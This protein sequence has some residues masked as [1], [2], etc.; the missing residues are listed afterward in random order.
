MW[1]KMMIARKRESQCYHLQGYKAVISSVGEK[2]LRSALGG[3]TDLDSLSRAE[4]HIALQFPPLCS[5]L[6]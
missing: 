4:R 3:S 2:Y 5:A 6:F 1:S